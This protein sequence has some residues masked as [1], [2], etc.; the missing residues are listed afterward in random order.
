MGASEKQQKDRSR[1]KKVTGVGDLTDL[2]ANLPEDWGVALLGQLGTRFIGGGTPSTK[3]KD[4]WNGD[5]EWTTSAQIDRLY[6]KKGAKTI[7]RKGLDNSSSNLLPKGN[8][9]IGTRVGVGKVAIN[10]VDVAISQDLTG[11]VVDT[12][13]AT[14]EYLA[15]A[16][17]SQRSQEV[18]RSGTRGVTI[19]GI[20]RDDLIRLPIALPALPEQRAI[21]NVLSTI[22]RAIDA[23]DKVIAA[24]RELK[25][26]LMRH[27][28]TYGPVPVQE[29]A[30][31][32][33]KETE[34]GLVPEHWAVLPLGEVAKI[35]NGSTPKRTHLAYWT[36][37]TIPWLTSGKVHETIITKAD[38]FVTST[39]RAECH[40]PLVRANSVLV[41][42][43]GE[44][45]TL[46]TAAL[47]TFDTCVSQHLA[48]IEITNPLVFPQFVLCYLQTRYRDFRQAAS[49]GGSTKGALT[50]AFLK[51]YAVPLPPHGEQAHIASLLSEADAKIASEENRKGALQTLFKTMLHL[52]M[53]GQV[54][55]NVQCRQTGILEV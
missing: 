19:K 42:I 23:Q 48:Y 11:M 40:L 16:L 12:N 5:V 15:Y 24:A 17:M 2:S 28:F 13:K 47:V 49:S 35:G 36:G 45:K 8:L 37:G 1:Q 9:L 21:A 4:Y 18:F 7:T 44:G 51:S 20:P 22:Q 39:A 27:L 46:G 41:A 25:K 3:V 31:V 43:T 33:L 54:R 52:L 50:C 32:P 38:E 55:V 10:L 29:A 14:P 6:L 34:I 30:R 26:S 53:T